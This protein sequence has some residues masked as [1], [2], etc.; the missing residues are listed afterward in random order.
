MSSFYLKNYYHYILWPPVLLLTPG[1][2]VKL[3]DNTWWLCHRSLAYT[4]FWLLTVTSVQ[5]QS[6]DVCTHVSWARSCT[7]FISTTPLCVTS[8]SV[9]DINTTQLLYSKMCFSWNWTRLNFVHSFFKHKYFTLT[10][11]VCSSMKAKWW[12]AFRSF[13]LEN[14]CCL[15]A[16]VISQ[17]NHHIFHQYRVKDAAQLNKTVSFMWGLQWIKWNTKTFFA[18]FSHSLLDA[19][20]Q[21]QLFNLHCKVSVFK[22]L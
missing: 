10:K 18:V 11:Y 6:N 19:E 13:M 3:L 17:H 2:K 15:S 1:N 14:V 8:L 20:Q 12:V 16:T 9:L 21:T 7:S 22:L 5:S 4:Y